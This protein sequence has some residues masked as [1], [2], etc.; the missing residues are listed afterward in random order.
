MTEIN[1]IREQ[2]DFKGIT[3]SGF[4]KTD[5]KKELLS[6]LINAKIEP[7]CYWSAEFICA[8]QFVDL[9][10]IIIFFYS[11]YVH[12]GNP[13]LAIYL[14][15][16]IQNFKEIITGGYASA[17]GELKLRN[18]EKVRKL[19]AEV[20]CI[21]C[22]AKRRHSFDE[23]KIKK[24]DYDMTLM[25]DRFKAPNASYASDILSGKDP[26]E[27]YIAI[28]EL[29]FS[30]SKDGKN[31]IQACY[32]IEWISEFESIC[33]KKKELCKCDRRNFAPV[34][35]KHQMDIIWLIWDT[36]LKEAT[37]RENPLLLK[38]IN[39]LMNLFSLKYTAGCISRRKFILYYVTA[40][41]TDQV[42]FEEDIVKEK[43]K[44]SLIVGKIGNI[45]K[46]IK[47]NE[48]SPKMDYLFKDFDKKSNLD[49]TIAKIEKMN[50]F[51]EEFIPRL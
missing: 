46:Q 3:F 27:L 49:K 45:Y 6:N 31:S 15:L 28:N 23:V 39:S 18:N 7:A 36:F 9:W 51:G 37:K 33:K 12:L 10:D 50:A 13:K 4:K 8:G 25:T 20:V 42:N 11:K 14:D 22:E 29:A 43:E 34:D 30:I 5:A 40:L 19:F 41:L 47:D 1:D 21:L 16:R 38:I 26:K 32:W 24:E 2:K 44:V 17:L 48:H 35:S